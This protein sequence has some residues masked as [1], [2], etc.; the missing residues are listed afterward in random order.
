[1][2]IDQNSCSKHV[3]NWCQ[4]CECTIVFFVESHTPLMDMWWLQGLQS[5]WPFALQEPVICSV[6]SLL[7]LDFFWYAQGTCLPSRLLIALS[8]H[9]FMIPGVLAPF[10]LLTGMLG[11]IRKIWLKCFFIRFILV[12]GKWEIMVQFVWV[13]IYNWIFHLTG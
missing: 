11:L 5:H 9:C 3:M 10:F 4:M 6:L 7:L 1:M 12:F 13:S 8:H 2:K